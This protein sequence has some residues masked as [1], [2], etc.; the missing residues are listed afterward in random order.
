MLAVRRRRRAGQIQDGSGR[1]PGQPKTTQCPLVNS[2]EPA[3]IRHLTAEP[4]GETRENH[5]GLEREDTRDPG[6]RLS[7]LLVV[8]WAWGLDSA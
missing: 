1:A 2:R 4:L 3:G 7:C 6:A 5:P 8:A